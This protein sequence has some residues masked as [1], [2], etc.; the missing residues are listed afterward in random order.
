MMPF[1]VKQFEK[2]N[3]IVSAS[4]LVGGGAVRCEPRDFSGQR[5]ICPKQRS[6]GALSGHEEW[7]RR[8]FP[9]CGHSP[10][11][12][13]LTRAGLPAQNSLINGAA[14]ATVLD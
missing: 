13:D 8:L 12:V 1:Y 5:A 11:P 3:D 2:E 7:S 6:R 4:G 9:C 14:L 10:F